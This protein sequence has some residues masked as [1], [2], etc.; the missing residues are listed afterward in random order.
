[1]TI[2]ELMEQFEPEVQQDFYSA[3]INAQDTGNKTSLIEFIDNHF[4]NLPEYL[5]LKEEL[6]EKCGKKE[7][8]EEPDDKDKEIEKLKKENDK[9]KKDMEEKMANESRLFEKGFEDFKSDKV[10]LDEMISSDDYRKGVEK[11]KKECSAPDV[12]IEKKLESFKKE[13]LS[14]LSSLIGK[15]DEKKVS[16]ADAYKTGLYEG[17]K[18]NSSVEFESDNVAL[19]E[20][21]KEGLA[22]GLTENE[23]KIKPLK[24][25]AEKCDVELDDFVD[26]VLEGKGK[27][28]FETIIES[29]NE[30]SSSKVDELMEKLVAFANSNGCEF[31]LSEVKK[32]NDMEDEEKMKIA[33]KIKKLKKEMDD[34][35]D[36]DKKA[37]ISEKIKKMKKEMDGEEEDDEEETDESDDEEDEDKKKYEEKIKKLKK[38]MDDEED[39]DKK[40]KISEKI[41]KMKKE[42]A[43]ELPKDVEEAIKDMKKGMTLA[44]QASLDERISELV[45]EDVAELREQ[46]VELFNVLTEE[47]KDDKDPE[48]ELITKYSKRFGK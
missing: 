29:V 32:E 33:E 5:D 8:E 35:E 21:F 18:G 2:K 25:L 3:F 20:A 11:A 38:E 10:N 9:L 42:M 28:A 22:E 46:L 31:L 27:E 26:L 15:K 4:V 39:E 12:V 16:V 1:M 43:N 17:R 34:E 19:A 30:S 37:K 24:K 44:E 13:L 48:Q 47:E 7:S 36:E 41:K 23:K 6:L 14:E 40:A 45:F